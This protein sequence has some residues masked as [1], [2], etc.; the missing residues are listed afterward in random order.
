MVMICR[1]NKILSAV[2]II[3]ILKEYTSSQGP[4]HVFIIERQ[5]FVI[6]QIQNSNIPAGH[7]KLLARF[8]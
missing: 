5:L 1:M 6:A 2:F 4:L 8:L 7:V 3:L